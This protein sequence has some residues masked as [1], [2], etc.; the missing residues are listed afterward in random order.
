MA[1]E[2]TE[3]EWLEGTTPGA[4]VTFLRRRKASGRKLRLFGCACC[5]RVWDTLT[6]PRSRR[7]VEVAE[8]YAD[9]LA[10]KKDLDEAARLCTEGATPGATHD[11]AAM[12]V[13]LSLEMAAH[14]ASYN[15]RV[16]AAGAGPI[17]VSQL[18]A[19]IAAENR[20]GQAQIRLVHDL[21]GN[22]FRPVTLDRAWLSPDVR[23]LAQAAYDNRTLP[24]GT[25]EPAR[26]AVLADALEDAGCD[27]ADLLAHLRGPGPHVRGCW[28]LDLLLGKA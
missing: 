28:A 12:V 26:L 25:L 1:K 13:K 18:A 15:A 5:R 4:M 7:A 17:E 16:R 14:R 20:E 2:M 23:A 3:R 8:E 11:P 9:K 19:H 21:F 24:A 6:D 22:P 10:K 27:H